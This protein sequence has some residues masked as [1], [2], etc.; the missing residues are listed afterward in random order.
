M[1]ISTRLAKGFG[2]L[3]LLFDPLYCRFSDLPCIMPKQAWT[4]S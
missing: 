3:I 2:L 1:K 4:M